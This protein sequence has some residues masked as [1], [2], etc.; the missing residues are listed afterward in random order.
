MIHN[1]YRT[2]GDPD[3]SPLFTDIPGILGGDFNAHH[4]SWGSAHNNPM[5]SALHDQISESNYLLVKPLSPTRKKNFIDLSIV[6][7]SLWLSTKWEI[8]DSFSSD[9]RAVQL[10]ITLP[11]N[12]TAKTTS[13]SPKWILRKADWEKYKLAITSISN[14]TPISTDI[15]TESTN[16]NDIIT[17]AANKHIPKTKPTTDRKDNWYDS[18]LTKHLK[19]AL[20]HANKQ[21]RKGNPS[22]T[23]DDIQE[24]KQQYKD[25]CDSARYNSWKEWIEETNMTTSMSKIWGHLNRCRGITRQKPLSINPLDKATSLCQNFSN[26]TKSNN[27]SPPTIQKLEELKPERDHNILEATSTPAHSDTPITINELNYAINSRK[28]D[29][30]P[31]ADAI[32][33]SLIKQLPEVFKSRILNLFNLI[34]NSSKLPTDWKTARLCAI[35]KPGKPDQFRPISL[36]PCLSKIQEIIM[37]RRLRHVAKPLNKSAFGFKKQSG[38]DDALANILSD[39]GPGSHPSAIVFLDLEKAFELANPTAIL[40]NLANRKVK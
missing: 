32:V 30:A 4:T 15:N 11:K 17:A 23:D 29:S 25:A 35:P 8:N 39:I 21:F 27:L 19:S 10:T 31:G 22:F 24:L 37:L 6:H 9:H 18:P 3:F 36:L 26:R 5:G 34:Y 28:K 7:S 33:Y 2:E 38:T 20:N 16:I 13:F 1:I 14:S 40:N 12:D